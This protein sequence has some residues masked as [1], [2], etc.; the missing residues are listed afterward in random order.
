M[1]QDCKYCGAYIAGNEERCPAC[2]KRVKADREGAAAAW[3]RAEAPEQER[4]P[5]EEETGRTDEAHTY[6]YKDEYSRRYGG[7]EG[8]TDY[9]RE[10]IRPR[11]GRGGA[12]EDVRQN[13]AMCYL[14]YLGPLFLVPY[15]LRRESPFVR[16]HSNQGLLLLLAIIVVSVCDAIPI[17]GWLISIL[18]TLFCLSCFFKGMNSVSKGRMDR[19]PVIGEIEILK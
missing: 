2:G 19:L 8:R 10:D 15:L 12:D 17:I 5:R 18:G 7:T 16:F 6:T 14:C 3:A 9:V 11:T 13:K 1:G 4:R